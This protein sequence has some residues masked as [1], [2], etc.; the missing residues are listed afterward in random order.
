MP[1]PLDEERIAEAENRCPPVDSKLVQDQT[2]YHLFKELIRTSVNSN[3][4]Q[5]LEYYRYQCAKKTTD[6]A[7][8]YG[9]ALQY[10]QLNQYAKALTL[11]KPLWIQAPN[12][13]YFALAIAQT[14]QGLSNP[15]AAVSVLRD[16]YVNFPDS[17]A[18]TLEYGTALL[19]AKE[20][21]KASVVLLTGTRTYKRDIP[22][23][24]QLARAQAA[25]QNLGYAYFTL[26]ECHILQGEH[27]DAVRKLKLA[28]TYTQ[29]DR[30][31]R[32]RIAAKITEITQKN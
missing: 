12:N 1:H 13:F 4:R 11:L 28:Q 8:R 21:S 18:I 15:Q 31:L 25:N 29:H 16:L 24:Q 2:N 27:R 3:P 17:Y 7:C 32:A 22:L 9:Y 19:A 10:I 23:C 5:L 6:L 14:Y 20:P 26:A 30:L